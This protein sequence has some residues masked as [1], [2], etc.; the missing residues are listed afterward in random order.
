MLA[1]QTLLQA[2]PGNMKIEVTGALPFGTGAKDL[3]LALV[4]QLGAAGSDHS[5]PG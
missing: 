2:K 1:T 5:E 4:G 3:A